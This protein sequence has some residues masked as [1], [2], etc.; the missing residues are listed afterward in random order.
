MGSVSEVLGGDIKF[1][2]RK[3]AR[4]LHQKMECRNFT[5]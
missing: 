3:M 5:P 1:F 2:G 4:C